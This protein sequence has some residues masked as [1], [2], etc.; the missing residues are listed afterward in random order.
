MIV[1]NKSQ[2][3][4]RKVS[5]WDYLEVNGTLKVTGKVDSQNARIQAIATDKIMIDKD[6]WT[7]MPQMKVTAN[8]D[9]PVLVLFKTGGVQG[10]PG[11]LVRAKFR[12]LI[13][14]T[15][16]A[17]TL[18]EFHNAG[19]ELRDVSLMWL[20]SL[21]PGDHVFNVQWSAEAGTVNACFYKDLR[22]LI[23]VKL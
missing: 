21:A 17:F 16:K 19:W 8:I 20:E 23:V 12:L 14:Q 10:Y 11:T 22:S 7:D 3:G 5:V 1:G 2:G 6:N 15:Q 9:G 4:V 13:D 18:H